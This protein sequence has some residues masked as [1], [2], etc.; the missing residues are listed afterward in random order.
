MASILASGKTRSY[1]SGSAEHVING[2]AKCGDLGRSN[3]PASR[4]YPFP[5]VTIRT[6]PG[7]HGDGSGHH[8]HQPRLG[9]SGLGV[10]WDLLHTVIEKGRLGDLDDE[11][12]ITGLGVMVGVVVRSAPSDCQVRLRLGVSVQPDRILDPHARLA[13]QAADEQLGKAIHD[14]RMRRANRGH[15][16]YLPVDELDTVV[17]GEYPGFAHA[18]EFFD[19]EE[20]ALDFD[21]SHVSSTDK[22]T[23]QGATQHTGRRHNPTPY[24]EC[25]RANSI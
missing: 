18:S 1:G 25:D 10:S 4:Q 6:R 20:V 21:Y 12:D 3:L 7:V 9:Y 2:E 24:I 16:A 11:K 5:T 14:S 15:F 8:V 13:G 19:G 23:G 17:P 22:Q